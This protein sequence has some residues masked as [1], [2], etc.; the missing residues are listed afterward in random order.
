MDDGIDR[1]G[2]DRD[3]DWRA[4]ERRLEGAVDRRALA[5]LREAVD[6]ET[7]REL[8]SALAALPDPG[9]IGGLRELGEQQRAWGG[10]FHGMLP[11]PLPKGEIPVPSDLPGLVRCAG[12]LAEARRAN[13]MALRETIPSYPLDFVGASLDAALSEDT[14]PV[15]AGWSLSLD[16]SGIRAVLALFERETVMPEEAA[17]IASMPAFVEMMRHRRDL[18]Y[19]PEPLITAEGLAGFLA[20]AASRD[21]VDR[22]W[23]WLTPQNFFDLA[24]LY[25]HRVAYSSFVDALAAYVEGIERRILGTIGRFAPAGAVFTD[26]LSFAVGWGIAGWA[27]DAT[28]GINIEHFKDDVDR[29]LLTLTHETFHRFQLIACPIDPTAT[30]RSFEALASFP[31]DSALDRKFYEVL[32][33]LFLEGTATFVAAAHPPADRRAQEARGAVLLADCERAIYE[34]QDLEQADALL[35]QGLRSNGPFYWYGALLADNIVE[36]GG[37]D[38]LASVLAMGSPH[39]VVTAL[40]AGTGSDSQAGK[41]IERARALDRRMRDAG[42]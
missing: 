11:E 4:L 35:N 18:G 24:D 26:R 25:E 31:F 22:I 37:K 38:G 20:R 8:I 36:Q 1:F 19:V 39:F 41:T 3:W 2:L 16:L 34:E 32:S 14:P 40:T 28:G 21:P 42:D 33:Y 13:L 23:K 5:A 12:F 17:G 9:A 10:G 7:A 29:L 27:T 15:P 6:L 30:D